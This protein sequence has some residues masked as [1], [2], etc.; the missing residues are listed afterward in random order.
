MSLLSVALEVVVV[1]G[2]SVVQTGVHS[3]PVLLQLDPGSVSHF[4][5]LKHPNL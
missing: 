5:C 1:G 3:L 2:V 4:S